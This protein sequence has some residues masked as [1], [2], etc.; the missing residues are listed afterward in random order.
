MLFARELSEIF[1][2]YLLKSALT[3]ILVYE[4]FYLLKLVTLI[5]IKTL[6]TFLV[7]RQMNANG[8]FIYPLVFG[9]LL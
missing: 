6:E 4:V 5:S 3:N 8:F 7:F 1:I 2:G 9:I